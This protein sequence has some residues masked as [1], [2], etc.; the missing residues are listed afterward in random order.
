MF[1]ATVS[2]A[3]VMNKVPNVWPGHGRVAKITEFGHK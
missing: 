1:R 3:T 2:A